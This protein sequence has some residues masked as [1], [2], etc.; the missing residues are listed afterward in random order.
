MLENIFV[1]A[2]QRL[3]CVFGLSQSHTE[4]MDEQ[5][6]I[7]YHQLQKHGHR[8]PH[9][10][11]WNMRQDRLSVLWRIKVILQRG[12]MYGLYD[13]VAEVFNLKDEVRK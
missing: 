9:F 3:H 12:A 10:G 8:H 6:V 2:V 1:Y 7:E 5:L 13:T 4:D 11:C